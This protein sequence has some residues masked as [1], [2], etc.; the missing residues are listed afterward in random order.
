M[1]ILSVQSIAGTCETQAGVHN[2]GETHGDYI[3]VTVF[4][5]WAH[6]LRPLYLS[7]ATCLLWDDE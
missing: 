7:E 6:V 1:F 2:K 3:F 5:F 4:A